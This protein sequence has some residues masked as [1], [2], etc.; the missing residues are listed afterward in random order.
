MLQKWLKS[1]SVTT[2]EQLVNVIALE[3]FKRKVPYSV[4]MHITSRDE[5]D[6]LK[7]AQMA[8]VFSLVHRQGP[9]GERKP[10]YSYNV[11]YSAGE[12]GSGKPVDS[13]TKSPLFC[14]FCKKPGHLIRNCANPRCKVAKG[15]FSKPVAAFNTVKETSSADLFAP[16][17]TQGT[18]SINADHQFPV[19]IVRDTAAAQTLILK[20]AVPGIE[21]YYTR[22][23]VYLKDLHD[24]MPVPL[25]RIHLDSPLVKGQVLVGVSSDQSLTVPNSELLLANA[26]AGGSVFPPLVI[27]E[28]PISYNPTGYLEEDQPNLFPVCAI[29]RAQKKDR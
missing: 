17:T 23:R 27:N 15:V 3:E 4:V 18:V 28:S 12:N 13:D 21:Q 25:A 10:D 11:R 19:R 2:F 9:S 22:E 29:T 6:L 14:S 1:A 16:F 5:H 24:P 8:D 20:S 26:L 7:A